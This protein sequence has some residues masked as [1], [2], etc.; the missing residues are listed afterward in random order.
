MQGPSE[1]AKK[2]SQS[3]SSPRARLTQIEPIN[4]VDTTDSIQ[5]SW[6]QTLAHMYEYIDTTTKTT[7]PP[8]QAVRDNDDSEAEEEVYNEELLR[9]QRSGLHLIVA[10][11][12]ILQITN[13]L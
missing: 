2:G 13:V 1:K 5:V 7:K 6:P 10:R 9:L 4:F 3:S 12:V 8:P 11:P